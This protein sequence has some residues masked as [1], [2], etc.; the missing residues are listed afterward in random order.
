MI[1]SPQWPF[2]TSGVIHVPIHNYQQVRKKH[3]A[4]W[5]YKECLYIPDGGMEAG[6]S[7]CSLLNSLLIILNNFIFNFKMDW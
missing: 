6:V 3:D 4:C 1:K 5:V 2:E 7:S